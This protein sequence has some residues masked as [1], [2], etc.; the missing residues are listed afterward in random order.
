M[1]LLVICHISTSSSNHITSH[2]STSHHIIHRPLPPHLYPHISTSLP[3]HLHLVTCMHT[4]TYTY[5]YARMPVDKCVCVRSLP[6]QQLAAKVM[7][8]L[9][10][11]TVM[12]RIASKQYMKERYHTARRLMQPESQSATC[13]CRQPPWSTPVAHH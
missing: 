12:K 2:Y 3:L 1:L 11:N 9:A 6:L 10:T 7:Q 5:K 13:I 8:R 4:R